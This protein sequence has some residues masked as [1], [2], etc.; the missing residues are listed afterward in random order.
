M[1]RRPDDLT[2]TEAAIYLNTSV[3]FVRRLVAERRIAFHKARF[4]TCGSLVPDLEAFLK[5]GRVEPTTVSTRSSVTCMGWREMANKPGHR[6]FGNV[7]RRES[8]R[9]QAQLPR[10]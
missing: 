10:S 4:P 1:T 5:A 8:G 2:V 6:R 9:W 7:R 3:R